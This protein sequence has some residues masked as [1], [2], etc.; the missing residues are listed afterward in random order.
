MTAF[1][2]LGLKQQ[3]TRVVAEEGYENPTPIQAKSIPPILAGS[4]VLGTAQTGTGKTA[5]FA[6]PIIQRLIDMPVDKTARG[7]LLPRVLVLSPTRE[8]AAQ[9]GDSFRTYGR[10]THIRG[11][12]I[13]GG[14]SQHH[15]VKAIRAGLDILVATPGRL[16]D[17]MEQG[18]V[19]LS[20]ISMFVLDEA[21]RML[22]M[23]FIQP[24]RQIAAAL[25]KQRQTLL[26]SATMPREIVHLAEALLKDP[27][28]VEVAPAGTT[29]AQIEEILYFVPFREKQSLLHHLLENAEASRVVVFTKT[30][31]GADKVGKRLMENGIESV[32]IH[33]NK[34]QNFRIRALQMFKTGRARVLVATDVAA[35]GLDVDGITHVFNYDLP[36][37]P[38][39]YVHRIG[40]TARAG[41]S[42][43]AIAF[44][45][46]SERELLRQIEKLTGRRIPKME[47]K[48]TGGEPS[49]RARAPL[50]AIGDDPEWSHTPVREGGERKP[51]RRERP[52]NRGGERRTEQG[53][54]GQQE[55]RPRR[56]EPRR[57]GFHAPKGKHPA[58]G[59]SGGNK[60]RPPAEDR[61]SHDQPKKFGDGKK[62]GGFK[63]KP[64][65]GPKR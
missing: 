38:E 35:R 39:S 49:S 11:T 64:R 15:Q 61:T 14:V 27:V 55:M 65:G 7:P 60:Q 17:L 48:L 16:T 41:A 19:N 30:K 22:D 53:P 9:I 40:R 26:F 36:M 46:P 21:D 6:L 43:H 63:G 59:H 45:D 28:R 31:H 51:A 44:C 8:L 24:I 5:A 42:G 25:P 52:T 57:E 56:D 29:A 4:D 1:S 62:F 33:G 23:G 20:N 58:A 10:D 50:A 2:A 37:E 18:L 13:F 32:V 12:V 3:V 47:T 54:R 34:A